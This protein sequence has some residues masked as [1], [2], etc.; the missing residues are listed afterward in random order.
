[1]K[2]IIAQIEGPSRRVDDSDE[3]SIRSMTPLG[4]LLITQKDINGDGYF[5]K[6]AA[7]KKIPQIFIVQQL[8]L[9][10]LFPLIF[11]T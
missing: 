3:K 4:D 5:T 10:K 11:K 6:T 8:D 7:E 9:L 1:M 2:V